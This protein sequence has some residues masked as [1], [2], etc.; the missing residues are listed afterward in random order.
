MSTEWIAGP[1]IG[2]NGL[3]SLRAWVA[4]DGNWAA[5]AAAALKAAVES[6]VY[7][8]PIQTHVVERQI[9]MGRLFMTNS[10]NEAVLSGLQ[11]HRQ[12]TTTKELAEAFHDWTNSIAHERSAPRRKAASTSMRRYG[13]L[14]LGRTP[15]HTRNKDLLFRRALKQIQRGKR[16]SKEDIAKS[17][18]W[19][20]EKRKAGGTAED[21]KEQRLVANAAASAYRG[22]VKHNKG[23]KKT[24]Q[25]MANR[26]KP[27]D[28][29][30][31]VSNEINIDGKNRKEAGGIK[32]YV[33]RVVGACFCL[34]LLLLP[35]YDC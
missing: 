6:R 18:K 15:S 7:P 25:Q 9:N 32:M 30:L 27:L 23:T 17:Q 8:L 16:L 14:P 4:A 19:K 13:K 10:G 28:L 24:A 11:R 1:V 29:P 21:R 22:A 34:C 12:N 3:A 20:K 5:P 35:H 33:V 2:K 26:V 31:V